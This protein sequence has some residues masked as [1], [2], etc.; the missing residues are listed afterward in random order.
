MLTNASRHGARIL[1][2]AAR[3][4]RLVTTQQIRSV[5]NRR[6]S[7]LRHNALPR[8]RQL[9]PTVAR[10][11]VPFALQSRGIQFSA[12]PKFVLKS[13]RVPAGGIALIT[14]GFAYVNYKVQGPATELS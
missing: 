9:L 13:F 6:P 3:H 4:S 8:T 1:R 7:L 10:A 5:H 2:T 11:G 12:L 14:G